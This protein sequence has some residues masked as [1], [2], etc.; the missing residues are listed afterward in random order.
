VVLSLCL[1]CFCFVVA[2]FICMFCIFMTYST[3]CCGH[4]K[5][6]DPW[7]VCTYVCKLAVEWSGVPKSQLRMPNAMQFE[8][9]NHLSDYEFLAHAYS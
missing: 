9:L 2:A 1:C 5:L 6:M 8:S 7:A 3:S 4:Y